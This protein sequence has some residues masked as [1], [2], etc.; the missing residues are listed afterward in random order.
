MTTGRLIQVG[1]PT[2]NNDQD[3]SVE[4]LL[5]GFVQCLLA[6]QGFSA[7]HATKDEESEDLRRSGW[8]GEFPA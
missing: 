7:K 2:K 3:V 6:E 4:Q 8:H 5:L 1:E